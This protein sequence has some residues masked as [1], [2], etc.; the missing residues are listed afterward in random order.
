VHSDLHHRAV[1]AT[2]VA[3]V[4]AIA[5]SGAPSAGAQ[6]RGSL[7]QIPWGGD[8]GSLTPYSFTT[9]YQFVTLVYDTLLWRDERGVPRPWL[10]RSVRVSGDGRRLSVR[11]ASNARWH[12]GVPLT[13]ADVAYT[14]RHLRRNPHPRFTPQ[15]RELDS[16]T[17]TGRHRLVLRLR[18]PSPG[19][20]DQPLADVPILPRHIWSRLGPQGIPPGLPVGSGPFRMVR[21]GAT[22]Y[23]FERNRR[24]FLGAPGVDAIQTRPLFSDRTVTRAFESR[25]IDIAQL[26]FVFGTEGGFEPEQIAIRS[27]PQYAAAMLMLNTRR[28]PFDD[29]RVRRGIAH[30][31]DL[32]RVARAAAGTGNSIEPAERGLLHPRSRWATSEDLHDFDPAAARRELAGL[33]RRPLRVLSEQP[34]QPERSPGR[35]IVAALRRVGVRATLVELPYERLASAIGLDRVG[36]NYDLAIWEISSLVSHDPEYLRTMF[37]R[38]GRLNYT[39]YRSAEFERLADRVTTARPARARRA[40]VARELRLLARDVPV[41]PLY[42]PQPAVGF[43]RSAW[44]GWRFIAG[45]GLLDKQSFMERPK[46]SRPA[47]SP[48]PVT[49]SRQIG[50]LGWAAFGVGGLA[51]S[52][53]LVGSLRRRR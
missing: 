51:L 20:L 8:E 18:R 29:P 40:A 50:P 31:L 13:A 32:P 36:E 24:Y 15:L 53:V 21:R 33:G 47:S 7:V 6:S 39:G 26:R 52:I 2:L 17:V 30:A 4:L 38:G 10:A 22:G 3:I 14:F 23:R 37:G 16:V 34:G 48:A 45:E 27:G 46:R 35:E 41:V 19:F 28:P 49:D 12:D 25:R 1:A 11:L 5:I 44:D 42:F 9:G 43:R